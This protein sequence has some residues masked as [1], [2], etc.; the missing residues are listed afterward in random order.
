MATATQK[1]ELEIEIPSLGPGTKVKPKF[2]EPKV[3][4]WVELE[5]YRANQKEQ[6]MMT[7]CLLI[8][9]NGKLQPPEWWG[10][11]LMSEWD[12]FE[13]YLLEELGKLK[14]DPKPSGEDTQGP[15]D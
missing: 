5:K 8:E 10:G 2:N 3:S 9:I 1:K 12:Q 6:R 4:D 15:L 13:A 7:A 14:K 11:R